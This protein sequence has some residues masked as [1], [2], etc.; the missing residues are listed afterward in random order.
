MSNLKKLLDLYKKEK[1]ISFINMILFLTN[2]YFYNLSGKKVD[3][4]KNVENKNFVINSINNFVLYNLNQTS[5]V[6]AINS[7]LYYE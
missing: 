2:K 6:N 4:L 1:N 5:L 3:L 7:K